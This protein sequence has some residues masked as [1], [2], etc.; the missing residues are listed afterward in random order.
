MKARSPNTE[1]THGQGYG[2]MQVEYIS[3]DLPAFEEGVTYQVNVFTK[4]ESYWDGTNLS[5]RGGYIKADKFIGDGS[6]LTGLTSRSQMAEAFTRLQRAVSDETTFD[7]LREALVNG[8]GGLIE[9]FE[10]KEEQ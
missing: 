1:F 4:L 6:S 8:L 10:Y 3:G 2:Y 7:G 9:S 5:V